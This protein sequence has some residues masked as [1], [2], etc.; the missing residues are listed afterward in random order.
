MGKRSKGEG[1]LHKM[2][3]GTWR[4]E[5]MDGYTDEGKRHVV[6]FS[7][8]TRAE[9]LKK[10]HDFQEQREANIHLDKKL[11]FGEF[12]DLW[13]G[14][15]RSQVQPSTYA[16]YKYTLALLKKRFGTKP[17]CEILPLD[18]VIYTSSVILSVYWALRWRKNETVRRLWPLWIA[19]TVITIILT[20]VLTYHY[21]DWQIFLDQ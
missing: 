18:I 17:L 19:V 4:A 11:S 20:G 15:Y 13:Y 5:L 3:N 9:V 8:K 14:D 1:N 2:E 12:A 16:G 10:I 7:G 21:P 6:R